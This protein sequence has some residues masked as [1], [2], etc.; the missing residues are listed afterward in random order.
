M[1]DDH[2]IAPPQRETMKAEMES[3]IHHFKHFTESYC[4]PEGEV[5]QAV[6]AARGSLGYYLAC[7][8][9]ANPYR[10]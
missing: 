3:L 8:G 1:L 6:E 10:A 5:Y 2:K 4:V 7:D 9:T